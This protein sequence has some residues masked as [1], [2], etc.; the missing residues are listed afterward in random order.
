MNRPARH[1]SPVR[2]WL[3]LALG[4]LLVLGPWAWPFLAYWGEPD[5]SFFRED[6]FGFRAGYLF[7][8]L[9]LGMALAGLALIVTASR[10]P[11]G[12][13]PTCTCNARHNGTDKDEK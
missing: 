11:A 8:P 9:W 4:F 12:P 3:Y 1:H 2:A 5:L 6:I 10:V 7:G 13:P